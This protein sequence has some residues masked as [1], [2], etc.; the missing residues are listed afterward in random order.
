M[1]AI[2][3]ALIAIKLSLYRRSKYRGLSDGNLRCKTAFAPN[4]ETAE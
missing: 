4:N 3:R 2:G 1:L